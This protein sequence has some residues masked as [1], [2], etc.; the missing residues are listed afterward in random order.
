MSKGLAIVT[1][2]SSGIGFNL[3]KELA[4]E[5]YDLI[6]CSAGDRLE[7]A[8]A[9]FSAFGNQVTAVSADLATTEGVDKLWEGL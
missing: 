3:A 7:A 4:S 2:A 1:G 9:E 6:V 8:A 5:G